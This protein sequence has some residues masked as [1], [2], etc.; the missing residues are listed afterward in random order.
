MKNNQLPIIFTIVFFA[1]AAIS[2]LCLWHYHASVTEAAISICGEAMLENVSAENKS[3]K[4]KDFLTFVNVSE[5][6]KLKLLEGISY[7]APGIPALAEEMVHFK[8]SLANLRSL[9]SKI[10]QLAEE[11]VPTFRV[12]TPETAIENAQILIKKLFGKRVPF[13]Q[14]AGDGSDFLLRF[15]CEN[16]CIDACTDG[17]IRYTADIAAAGEKDLLLSALF[18]QGDIS[19]EN[20]SMEAGYPCVLLR[21]KHAIAEVSVDPSTNRVFTAKI[22]FKS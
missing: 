22:L 15:Y 14:E 1:V 21:G 19:K 18:P 3:K 2:Y 6:Q 16:V 7:N 5:T 10:E 12:S 8:Y 13:R 17:S 11:S 4:V 20:S 9:E